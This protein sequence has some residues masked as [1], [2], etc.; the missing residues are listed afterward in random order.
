MAKTTS[1]IATRTRSNKNR[2]THEKKKCHNMNG[3]QKFRLIECHVRLNRLTEQQIMSAVAND[4][5]NIKENGF[6]HTSKYNL[7]SGNEKKVVKVPKTTKKNIASNTVAK[8][9]PTGMTVTRLWAFL[10]KEYAIP[11][12]TNLYCLAKMRKYSPWP[13]M[14]TEFKGKTSMVYFFGEGT[15]GTVQTA[16]IVP[17]NKCLVLAKKYLKTKGYLRAVRE[18]ELALNIPQNASITRED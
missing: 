5:T 14:V 15:T 7:R 3:K 4:L 1:P 9:T 12:F 10:K 8:I 13:A 16:E 6:E 17:F 2:V 18:L 11:P